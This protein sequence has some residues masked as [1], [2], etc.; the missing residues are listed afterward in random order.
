[1]KNSTT[2]YYPHDLLHS[3]QPRYILGNRLIP[4]QH[5]D[6]TNSALLE[7]RMVHLDILRQRAVENI[8]AYRERAKLRFDNVHSKPKKYDV[9]DLVLVSNESSKYGLLGKTRTSF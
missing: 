3:F 7:Q 2:K 5:D 6:N 9:G 4:L 8:A 1:M